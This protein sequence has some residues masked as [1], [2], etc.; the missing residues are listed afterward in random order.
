M[1]HVTL[2]AG[3]TVDLRDPAEIPERLRRPLRRIQMQLASSPAFASVV[4]DAS[5]RGAAAVADIPEDQAVAM[6]A[7]MG[8]EAFDLMDQ[9]NDRAVLAKVMGW[10]FPHPV[11]LEGLQELSGAVYDELR[12]LCA[13]GA[14]D[15]PDFS[16]SQDASSPT[17]PS[18]ACA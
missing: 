3:G 9:L 10:S 1:E 4:K 7:E 8:P 13:A 18:T 2:K 12:E 17:D 6:V 11:T 14:L 16:P 5:Q 15:G